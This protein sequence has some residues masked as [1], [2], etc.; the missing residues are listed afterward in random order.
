[1]IHT[2]NSLLGADLDQLCATKSDTADVC[3]D[4]IGDDQAD[5]QEEPDHALED[6]VHDEVGLNDNQVESHVSP[7][8]LSELELVVTLLERA[9]EKDEA[10]IMLVVVRNKVVVHTYPS[11]K[12]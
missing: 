7:S 5:W 6:V 9:N 1:M 12:A 8:K 10:W 2:F 11:R 3:K 4:V